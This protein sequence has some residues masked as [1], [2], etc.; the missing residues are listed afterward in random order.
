MNPCIVL[1]K[2]P[3]TLTFEEALHEAR[4]RATAGLGEHEVYELRA[5]V[6]TSGEWLIDLGGMMW[7]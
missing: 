7:C 5:A 4:T 1:R 6:L 2:Q 3:K